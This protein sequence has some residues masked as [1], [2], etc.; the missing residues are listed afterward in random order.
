[1]NNPDS[2]SDKVQPVKVM[3]A[4]DIDSALPPGADAEERFNQFWRENGTS[5][6]SSIALGAIVVIGVQTWR[7]FQ[8]RAEE[9]TQQS[10]LQAA[11][12][13]ELTVFAG[14]NANHPLAGASYMKLANSEFERGEYVQAAEHYALA[15]EKLQGSAFTERA[16]LGIAMCEL[17]AGSKDKAKASLRAIVDNADMLELTRAEAAFNLALQYVKEEDFKSLEEIISITDTFAEGN[18]YAISTGAMG[19]RIPAAK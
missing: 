19:F 3:R 15:S 1:M 12:A 7:Y 5:I 14:D 13:E 11:S 18:N 4:S 9:K 6:F 16:A 8:N 2:S 17:L 10:F